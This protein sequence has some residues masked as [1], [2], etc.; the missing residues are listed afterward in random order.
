MNQATASVDAE[1][2]VELTGTDEMSDHLSDVL[3]DLG[4]QHK[5]HAEL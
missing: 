1:K 5:D 2:S 3:S 4:S